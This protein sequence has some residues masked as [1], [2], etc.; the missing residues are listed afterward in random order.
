M[1]TDAPAAAADY[2]PAAGSVRSEARA[3]GAA[4]RPVAAAV[5]GS[6][7]GR[8]HS[9][10]EGWRA[11]PPM[12]MDLAGRL[13]RWDALGLGLRASAPESRP[14]T[15]FVTSL[16]VVAVANAQEPVVVERIAE[17]KNSAYGARSN[18]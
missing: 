10:V 5:L 3:P 11:L 16:Q 14:A 7:R 6:A 18:G 1:P 9:L 12:T 15:A 4:G 2:A 17:L 8:K 13:A